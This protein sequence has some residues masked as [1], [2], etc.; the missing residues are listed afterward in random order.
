MLRS[1]V[2][3]LNPFPFENFLKSQ[4]RKA[5]SSIFGGLLT[6]T[7]LSLVCILGAL[8]VIQLTTY[9]ISTVSSQTNYN[10]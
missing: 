1:L 4:G 5:Y 3:G 10:L 9:G 7:L 6:L 2:K 8:K